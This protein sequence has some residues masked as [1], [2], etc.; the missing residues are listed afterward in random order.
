[1]S[2]YPSVRIEGGLFSPDLLDQIVSAGLS[3]Q[4]P[5]DFGLEPRRNMTDEIAA[6]FADARALWGVFQNRL[7][8][9]SDP[10]DPATTV[11][12]DYWM[13]PF[14]GLIGFDLRFNPK[15]YEVDGL[16]FA[17][18]HRAGEAEDSPPIH[19]VGA[20]QEL[21][22]LA[23]S[24]RPRL[25]PHS[26]VQEFLNRTDHVWGV[27]SNGRIL[28]LLRDSTYIRRQ[29][30]VEFD[31]QAIFEDE[32]F[33]DFGALFRL[34]HRTRFPRGMADSPDCLLEKYYAYSV[35]QGGRV[36]EHM[37]EGVEECIR[38]LAGGFL[39][40]PAN[41][42]LRA[43]IRDNRLTA[44]GL[45]KQLLKLVYRF[46][47]LLVAEDRGLVSPDAVYR[48]HY[49]VGRLRRLLE[50]RSS[51]S[52]H[53]DLWMGLRVLWT[54]FSDDKLAALLSLAPLN[55]ELF[56]PLDLDTSLISNSHLLEG[57]GRLANYRETPSSPDRRVNYSAIDVEEM[58]SV[59]ESLLEFHPVIETDAAGR[60]RFEL[61]I[62]SER[63]TTGSYYTPPELVNEIIQSALVPV[64]GERLKSAASAAEKE[65]AVLALRICDPAC[66]SGHFLLAA[67]RR[68][69]KELARVRT[70]EDEPAPE[71]V[72]ECVRDVIAH[73]IYGV[74]KNPLAVDLCRVALWIE[75]HTEGK[76]LTFL[77]HRVLC[78]DSLVGVFD[79]AVLK[80]G[81]PDEAFKPFEGDDKG[82]ARAALN[83]NRAEKR[84]TPRL[85]SWDPRLGMDDFCLH[86]RE[87]EAIAD[88]SPEHVR[89]KKAA[90]EAQ[91]R[92]KAWL[93]DKIA[94]DLW[95]A[96]FF[97]KY[98]QGQPPITTRVV[99]EILAG[100]AVDGRLTG[101]A[102]ALSL[103][104]TFFHWP[105]E[106]PEV[107]AQGGFDVVLSNPPWERIKLQEQEFFAVRDNNIAE[108]P[109]KAVRARMI[110]EL[111]SSHSPLFA[112]YMEAV[113][114]A[115]SASRFLRHGG[116]FPLAGRGDINTYAVFAEL[117]RA[118]TR[119][120]GRSG[121]IIP[122]GIA[123]DD[124]TKYF[125]QDVMNSG[126]LVS[127]F[128]FE[129]RKGIF[130][131]VHRSY[132]FCLF[133]C[134]KPAGKESKPGATEFVFF[135]H[136]VEDL[137]EP[138]RRFTL[139]SDEIAL[140]NPNT[141]NCP[142]FRSRADAELTKAIYRRVPILWREAS[143]GLPESNPWNLR[144]F[145]LFHMANDSHHFRTAKELI[146]LECR[147]E[148]N[149]FVGP[150]ARYL[151]LYEAKM[152]HQ[153]DHR[154]A[155]YEER[156]NGQVDSRDVTPKEKRDPNF[157]VQPR[158]WVREDI[159]E[160]A[161][162]EVARGQ[163][164]FLG[165]RNICR[166]TDERTTISTIFPRTAVGHAFL[167][168]FPDQVSWPSIIALT[169][170]MNSYIQDYSARQKLGGT[171]FTYNIFRQISVPS[172]TFFE[173]ASR[174][175]SGEKIADWISSRA[176]GLL[177][178][179]WDLAP[180][181]KAC[182]FDGPPFPWNEERRFELRCELDAAFFHLYLPSNAHGDWIQAEKETSSQLAELVAYFPTPRAAVSYVLDQFPIVQEK[183][184]RRFGR[185][186]TK[187][188]IL[189]I[190][191]TLGT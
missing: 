7:D 51:F 135:A 157:V 117:A 133:T 61:A 87:V 101:R 29:A 162:P 52:D 16:S 40:H 85:F 41:D 122:S 57:F 118:L 181:A 49:G 13:I 15:A 90:F 68:L 107:F 137:K 185:F 115:E 45:Y 10:S 182:G 80:D 170:V 184:E 96:A 106:F 104:Q 103:S 176:L 60:L 189:A 73:C 153:F 102:E 55:G 93:R 99:A 174:W 12:R 97:Q 14:F 46:I 43:K 168:I 79:L 23:A 37:R 82:A 126:S 165:W 50:K 116:K 3:G 44:A 42:D 69:G 72:R 171:N 161:I 91:H 25:A 158:Y 22:R 58:G 138:A 74:D 4:K 108:A 2:L 17:V 75:G 142:I 11:T 53:T 33:V 179:S 31:L 152:L 123:T 128:D 109:N 136:Q 1:M 172:P 132:K 119:P 148:G 39:G 5:A 120:G 89:R 20:R 191:D 167:L 156:P 155:T 54:V 105:L 63:K 92:D 150:Q 190:Y 134:E 19:I 129:N 98:V 166:A 6:V 28:R 145:T 34:L 81:I 159:V 70:G 77:D 187:E 121:I 141:G 175:D 65:K 78:G 111:E 110:K 169:S 163:Q 186:R 94:C 183:D 177:Y 88:D 47:F 160:S 125:F 131:S 26:L 113:R 144:F 48:E 124:T 76:P 140:L 32:R 66:G 188:Q 71:R 30:Y 83:E 21:G 164:W 9:L 173:K 56:A 38:V 27:V 100:G 139:S 154:W 36:R 127:L 64:L 35:E 178:T 130:A 59:Y 112:E 86:C 147:K 180:F 146:A 149:I 67:A 8:R 84:D 114:H 18:S 151:P 95:T 62:G 143:E 24:G